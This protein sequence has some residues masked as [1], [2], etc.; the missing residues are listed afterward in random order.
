MPV[1]VIKTARFLTSAFAP[2][3]YPVHDVPEIAFAGRS[4]VGKS[5]LINTLLNRKKLVR[6]SSRPGRTQSLNFFLVNDE[7][8]FVDLPG[9]GYAKVPQEVRKSWVPMVNSYL[10]QRANLKAVVL[11]LDVRREPSDTDLNLRSRLHEFGIRIIPTVTKIDK[12][13]RNKRAA[14]LKRI[15]LALGSGPSLIPFS[16]VTGE[17]RQ[18]LWEALQMHYII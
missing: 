14:S 5:S 17:G 9:Y 6:T 8:C 15:E 18:P 12:V 13:S 7:L 4:N 16:S 10:T 1:P 3:Q 11:I 2:S